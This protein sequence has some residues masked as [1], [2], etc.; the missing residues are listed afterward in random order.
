MSLILDISSLSCGHTDQA[1]EYLHKAI[2]EGDGDAI[3]DEHPSPLVRKLIE[4]FTSRGLDRLETV[5][6]ELTEWARGAHSTGGEPAARPAGSMERWSRDELKLVRIYLE[7]LPP[8]KWTFDDHMMMVDYLFQRYLPADELKSEAQWLATRS[9]LMGR[10]Q[11]SLDAKEKQADKLA[12]A[13]PLTVA[14]AEKRFTLTPAQ[15]ETLKYASAHAAENVR[16][17]NEDARHALRAIVVRRA[18]E[19]ATGQER[20][21]LQTEL[22]DRFAVLNRDWRRIAVTEA[23]EALNQGYVASLEPGQQVKRVE[24][25]RGACPFCRKIDG[26]IATVVSPDKPDK[27]GDTEIWVG[28]DNIGRSAAPRKRVGDQLVPR[29][30]DELWWLPAGLAHPNCRGRWIPTIKPRPGDDPDFHKW[31][32]ETLNPKK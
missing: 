2:S 22:M 4:L 32:M 15:T 18:H 6:K 1:L 23:G 31:M 12:A 5:R 19:R 13:L 27:D 17:F 28:K 10:V 26:A 3:W 9:T 21:A 14:E 25:Y 30:V 20:G 16:A 24:Q 29:S 11:T 8:A 7:K